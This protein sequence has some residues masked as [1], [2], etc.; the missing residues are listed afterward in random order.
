MR[1]AI[2]KSVATTIVVIPGRK[3]VTLPTRSNDPRETAH[4][5]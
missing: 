4:A 2:G 3:S 5:A 1:P